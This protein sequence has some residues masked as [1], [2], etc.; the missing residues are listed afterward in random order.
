M[1]YGDRAF[2][3]QYFP[4]LLGSYEK[5]LGAAVEEI[6][7]AQPSRIVVA[8]AAEGYYAVGLAL[9]VPGA[10]VIAFEAVEEARRAISETAARNGVADRLEVLGLC[11][12]PAIERALGSGRN[13]FLLCDVE[14]A[15]AILLDPRVLPRLREVAVLVETHDFAVPGVEAELRRRFEASHRLERFVAHP[16]TAHDAIGFEVPRSWR[17]ALEQLLSERRPPANGWLW[18]VPRS[19]VRALGEQDASGGT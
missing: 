17:G 10:R 7:S 11:D 18:M 8:G 3:S 14:G 1:V 15:E 4:K 13:T 9:R 16:R 12:L 2:G 5:E 6:L 19:E